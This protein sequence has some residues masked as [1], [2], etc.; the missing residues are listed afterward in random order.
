MPFTSREA[1]IAEILGPS[2]ATAQP[3]RTPNGPALL[4]RLQRIR[5]GERREVDDPVI[6]EEPLEIVLNGQPVAV[7]MRMP[8]DEKELAAGFGQLLR[9]LI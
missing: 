2:K 1:S 8:G 9:R 5:N 7:L 3:E 6:L 4:W